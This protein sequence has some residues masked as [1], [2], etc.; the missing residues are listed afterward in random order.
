[1]DVVWVGFAFERVS[2][3]VVVL[4]DGMCVNDVGVG[5]FV[6]CDGGCLGGF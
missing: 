3:R 6:F 5:V 2:R 4:H 1:M